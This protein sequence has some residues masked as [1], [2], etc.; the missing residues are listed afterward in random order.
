MNIQQQLRQRFEAALSGRVPDAKTW[1]GSC[2]Q[3]ASAALFTRQFAAMGRLESLCRG[4]SDRSGPTTGGK[5]TRLQNPLADE[6]GGPPAEAPSDWDPSAAERGP[7]S[8]FAA[9]CHSTRFASA[10]R[11]SR[12]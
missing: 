3:A 9:G 5:R 4:D 8:D 12:S 2:Q 11:F 6:F 10:H 1:A 7:H